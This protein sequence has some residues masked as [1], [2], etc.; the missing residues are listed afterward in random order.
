MVKGIKKDPRGYEMRWETEVQVS[1]VDPGGDYLTQ[2]NIKSIEW[3]RTPQGELQARAIIEVLIRINEQS[4]GKRNLLHGTEVFASLG[5]QEDLNGAKAQVVAVEKLEEKLLIQGRILLNG[6]EEN[7]LTATFSSPPFANI[8]GVVLC[9][10][11]EVPMR[12]V[13]IRIHDEEGLAIGTITDGQGSFNVDR[14]LPGDYRVEVVDD[15]GIVDSKDV[16]IAPGDDVRLEFFLGPRKKSYEGYWPM[17]CAS[18]SR[19]GFLQHEEEKMTPPLTRR[20]LTRLEGFILASPVTCDE[21]IYLCSIEHGG[22][23]IVALNSQDGHVIW[24]RS[25]G[26]DV[27]ATPTVVRGAKLGAQSPDILYVAGLGRRETRTYVEG[28]LMAFD[29]NDGSLL[30]EI[31]GTGHTYSSPFVVHRIPVGTRER[32]IL[33]MATYAETEAGDLVDGS[34]HAFDAATGQALWSEPQQGLGNIFSSLVYHHGIIYGASQQGVVSALDV[35]TGKRRWVRNLEGTVVATPSALRGRLYLAVLGKGN[36]SAMLALD[37]FT[38]EEIWRFQ[39]GDVVTTPVNDGERIYFASVSKEF[40]GL[41]LSASAFALDALTGEKIWSVPV[42]DILAS[43]VIVGNKLIMA[44]AGG[45]LIFLDSS[46]GDKMWKVKM[47]GPILASPAISQD[48]IIISAG[49]RVAA[50]GKGTT[51]GMANL[52]DGIEKRGELFRFANEL[53]G[54]IPRKLTDPLVKLLMRTGIGI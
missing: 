17:F 43:P 31:K 40:Y 50:F 39:T 16:D 27:F 24:E 45:N 3:T 18:P 9:E 5:S 49:R 1:G 32:S 34:V 35:D 28:S 29:S 47:G 25:V 19:S 12:N 14:V 52:D 21:K 8:S 10:E 11:S 37:A 33:C 26:E 48:S 2:A 13:V 20:W 6:A 41:R 44:S 51:G 36:K 38:G 23:R 15:D 54:R 46:S 53:M 30:W 7:G 4:G 42:E 22:S